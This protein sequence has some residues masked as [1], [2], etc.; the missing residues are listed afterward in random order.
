MLC[1]D[2]KGLSSTTPLPA[3]LVT[4][5]FHT[6]SLKAVSSGC[7][8]IYACSFCPCAPFPPSLLGMGYPASASR[9]SSWGAPTA[10]HH[11]SDHSIRLRSTRVVCI[12]PGPGLIDILTVCQRPRIM[13]MVNSRVPFTLSVQILYCQHEPQGLSVLVQFDRCRNTAVQQNQNQN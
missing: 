10:N 5:A 4:L 11:V 12:A 1:C 9:K 2:F 6:V 8:L 7:I 3:L 13:A